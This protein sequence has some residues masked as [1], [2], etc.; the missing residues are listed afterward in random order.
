MTGD[1]N[2][3]GPPDDVERL[4]RLAGRRPEV[5]DD[6]LDRLRPLALAAMRD[7]L[8]RRADSRRRRLGLAVAALAAL[9]VLAVATGL[10]GGAG[11]LGD[12]S[13]PAPAIAV[14]RLEHVS[15][16]VSA[17][18]DAVVAGGELVAG[19]ELATGDA[20]S[21]AGHAALATT[22]GHRL[23]LDAGTRLAILDPSRL[24]LRA[25]AVYVETG[26]AAGGIEIGTPIGSVRDLGTRF[27]LRL[28][29]DGALLVRVRDGRVALD[30]PT[31]GTVEAAAGRELRAGAEGPVE[32]APAEVYGASWD[33]IAAASPGFAIE[34]RPLRAYLDWVA[35]EAGW[36]LDLSAPGLDSAGL[37]PAALDTLLHGDVAGLD[38][39]AALAVVLS[40][41]GLGYRLDGGVLRVVP[42]LN[43]PG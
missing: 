3:A 42:E 5:A 13:S 10:L 31:G 16:S 28:D 2:P 37:D 25:G 9:V 30:R 29:G 7:G 20:A 8:A 27:E 22:A 26:P 41:C 34:G 1:Q 38:R 36:S 14:A 40:G 18:G 4:L 32:Q 33:W 15:G 12:A 39:E 23:R 17:A 35:A 21:G 24:E 19:T 11:L 6:E 43:A